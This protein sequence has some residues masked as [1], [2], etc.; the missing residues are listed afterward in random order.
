MSFGFKIFDATGQSVL[1]SDKYGFT[2][3]DV[4]DVSPF[5]S[6]SRNYP[7]LTNVNI[8]LT[9]SQ[10]EPTIA[11]KTA[12]ASFNAMNLSFSSIGGKTIFW[13]PRFQEG[14]AYDVTIYVYTI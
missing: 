12:I 14:T 10:V 5:S 2:L 9:Q 3:V 11:T 1:S 8:M 7:D 4:F 6:G 13:S